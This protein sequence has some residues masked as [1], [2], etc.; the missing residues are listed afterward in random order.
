[1][2]EAQRANTA[3][4]DIND[5]LVAEVQFALKGGHFLLERPAI[6]IHKNRSYQKLLKSIFSSISY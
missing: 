6:A 1:M 5:D 4:R 3:D 2:W